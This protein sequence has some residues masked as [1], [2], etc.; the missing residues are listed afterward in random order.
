MSLCVEVFL[1]PEPN[2]HKEEKLLLLV[3]DST[4]CPEEITHLIL[5]HKSD[6]A[7]PQRKLEPQ[8]SIHCQRYICNDPERFIP[9]HRQPP[10]STFESSKV[11]P[12]TIFSLVWNI[13]PFETL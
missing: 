4:S 10:T 8:V 6:L 12:A 3:L 5:R 2:I 1:T 7:R 13:G 11:D 9:C